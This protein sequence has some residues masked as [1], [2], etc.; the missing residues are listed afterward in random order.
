[1]IEYEDIGRD[2]TADEKN[3]Q[4]TS[5]HYEGVFLQRGD[6]KKGSGLY[7]H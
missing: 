5:H 4:K 1:V 7:R 2:Y 6:G 3:D